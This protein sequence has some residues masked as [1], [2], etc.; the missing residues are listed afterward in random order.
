MKDRKCVSMKRQ[1]NQSI[2]VLTLEQ[3]EELQKLMRKHFVTALYAK[4]ARLILLLD[5][6]KSITEAARL[7]E[8]ERRHIYK[9]AYRYNSLGLQGLNDLKR[10]GRPKSKPL[11]TIETGNNHCLMS[12]S[13]N[14]T[15]GVET[16]SKDL[17][18]AGWK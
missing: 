15:H 10:P 3:R 18:K 7:I 17:T 9:W 2:I 4:R 11:T 5:E 6:G 13:I 16:G 14:P 1:R 12:G 8:M